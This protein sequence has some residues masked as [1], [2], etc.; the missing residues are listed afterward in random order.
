MYNK[1]FRVLKSEKIYGFYGFLSNLGGGWIMTYAYLRVSTEKQDLEKNK[2]DI[3]KLANEKNLGRVAFVEETAS[4]T[5]N[6][7][8]RKI[9]QI[10]EKVKSGD[11]IIVSELSRLGRSMLEVMSLLAI[12]TEK[13]VKIFAVKGGWSLD[14]SLQSKIVAM[15]FSI[16]SEIERDLISLRTK[17]ALKALKEKGVQLGRPKGPGKSKL[18]QYAIEIKAL[19]ENG[20]TKRFIAKRYGVSEPTLQNWLKKIKLLDLSD[21]RIKINI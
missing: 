13:G 8:E 21:C 7:R 18:D 4:G 15:A 9:G 20:S 3:L 12:A 14:N 17:E 16:A 5:I 1:G 11:A 2:S 6:W 19:L 10:I